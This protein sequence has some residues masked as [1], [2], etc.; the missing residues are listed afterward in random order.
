MLLPP[1]LQH[2]QHPPHRGVEPLGEQGEHLDEGVAQ[3]DRRHRRHALPIGVERRVGR[4]QRGQ[5][6]LLGVGPPL[7]QRRLPAPERWATPS[8]VRAMNPTSA[9]SASVA[10]WI[11]ASRA[12]PRR[13][14]TGRASLIARAPHRSTPDV[15]T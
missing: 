1:R 7:V 5:H 8:I 15:H 10:S 13:R 12:E 2:V 3:V 14:C 4:G 6:E 11:A 9:S